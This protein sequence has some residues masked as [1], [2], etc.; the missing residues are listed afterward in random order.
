MPSLLRSK[1][2]GHPGS[3]PHFGQHIHRIHKSPSNQRA[4]VCTTATTCSVACTPPFLPGSFKVQSRLRRAAPAGR[5]PSD[6]GCQWFHLRACCADDPGWVRISALSDLRAS[7]SAAGRGQAGE[8][9]GMSP[10]YMDTSYELNSP[11]SLS[12]EEW[13][14][15]TAGSERE[16]EGQQVEKRG[17]KRREKNRDAARKSRRK[18]TERADELHESGRNN[19]W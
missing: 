15:N 5:H 19:L 3:V 2:S 4:L 12:A 16:G 18:Q 1:A 14:S 6:F 10:L 9:G 13:N 8:G 17:I 11:S 7:R